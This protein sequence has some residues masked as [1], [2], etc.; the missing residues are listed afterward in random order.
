[1]MVG[2]MLLPSFLLLSVIPWVFYL[3]NVCYHLYDIVKNV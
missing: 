2:G 3:L 1:M